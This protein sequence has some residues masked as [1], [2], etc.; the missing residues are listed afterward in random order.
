MTHNI[1]PPLKNPRAPAGRSG[2]WPQ[3]LAHDP[4]RYRG[5][6]PQLPYGYAGAGMG[7]AP[8][9]QPRPPPAAETVLERGS[10]AVAA[11]ILDTA[12]FALGTLAAVTSP[13]QTAGWLLDR[14]QRR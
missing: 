10:E 4:A 12:A 7:C 9:P 5:G 14:T 1:N 3:H 8:Q 13:V 6:F 2:G 11:L